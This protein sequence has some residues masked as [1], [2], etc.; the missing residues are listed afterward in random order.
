MD[1][2]GRGKEVA[3]EICFMSKYIHTW[4]NISFQNNLQNVA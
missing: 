1:V 3:I 2:F 4:S